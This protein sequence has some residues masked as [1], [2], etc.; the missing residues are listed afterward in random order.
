MVLRILLARVCLALDFAPVPSPV[1]TASKKVGFP[2]SVS[3]I[4]GDE[5]VASRDSEE[6]QDNLANWEGMVSVSRDGGRRAL[7]RG[8][9]VR[10]DMQA[11]FTVLPGGGVY[12]RL[13]QWEEE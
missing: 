8:A 3:A 11:G 1:S 7:G 12:L 9:S 6:Q 13:R 10:K 2:A 5:G 4:S